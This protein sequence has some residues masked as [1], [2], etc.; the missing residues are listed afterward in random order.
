MQG[1]IGE[2]ILATGSL[3]GG[4]IRSVRIEYNRVVGNNTGGI[5]P[6][7]SS[8]YP[9]CSAAGQI[10]GDCGEGIHLMGA[11]DSRVSGNY[12]LGNEGGV[13]LTDEF[14]PTRDNLVEG[15]TITR[16]AFDCGV[17]ALGTTRSP[18]TQAAI[19][20]PQWPACTTT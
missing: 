12:V 5:P 9:Q 4:S 3:A 7:P 13:L 18:W 11:H 15:D 16:N 8:P 20:S 1:A 6:T 2:G 10:P 17:T 19:L 14:G